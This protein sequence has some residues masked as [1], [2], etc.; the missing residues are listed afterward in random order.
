MSDTRVCKKCKATTPV[1][2]MARYPSGGMTGSCKKCAWGKGK[3]KA[4]V[5]R[6]A[7]KAKHKFAL[8]RYG[9]YGF[10]A[11]VD[12]DNILQISQSD[13]DGSLDQ[14]CFTREEFRDI[15]ATF[16]PWAEM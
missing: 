11:E 12:G 7:P 3:G 15:I 13:N 14:V 8:E 10:S 16:K 9:G 2:D 1:E 4:A 5:V 6:A